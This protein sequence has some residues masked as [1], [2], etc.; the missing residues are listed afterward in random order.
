MEIAEERRGI[1]VGEIGGDAL[2]AEVA[3][4]W[5]QMVCLVSIGRPL[6]SMY[7]SPSGSGLGT[8]SESAFSSQLPQLI[9][10]STHGDINTKPEGILYPSSL[11]YMHKAKLNPPPAESPA[12][13]MFSGAIE[14]GG[15]RSRR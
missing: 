6:L 8:T 7:N 14:S 11:R 5:V 4:D 13:M 9:V 10:K 3:S 15:A 1:G 2:R 12:M